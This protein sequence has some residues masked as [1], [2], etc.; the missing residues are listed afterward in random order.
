MWVP[1]LLYT[2]V[3]NEELTRSLLGI[4]KGY[5]PFLR[6]SLGACRRLLR[7]ALSRGIKAKAVWYL[8]KN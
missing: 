8:D 6:E 3:S 4:R 1:F 5:I 2:I 7:C